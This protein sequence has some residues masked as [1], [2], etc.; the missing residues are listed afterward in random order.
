MPKASKSPARPLT[1]AVVFG[2]ENTLLSENAD[3]WNRVNAFIEAY[4]TNFPSA[5][6]R[7]QSLTPQE[8][9]SRWVILPFTASRLANHGQFEAMLAEKL[10][11]AEVHLS[12]TMEIVAGNKLA[13]LQHINVDKTTIGST[14]RQAPAGHS[15]K[16][17]A[18]C[19]LLLL[20]A[21]VVLKGFW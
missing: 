12:S 7:L 3:T 14:N 15:Y 9:N 5:N 16:L 18:L 4:N 8:H 2:K 13:T 10:G 19:T 20:L 11:G 6:L 1:S 17:Y 21:A